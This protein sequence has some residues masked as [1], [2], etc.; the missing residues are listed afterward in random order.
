[1]IAFKHFSLPLCLISVNERNLRLHLNDKTRVC[2]LMKN[3]VYV[4][5]IRNHR[6]FRVPSFV[7]LFHNK[8]LSIK[9]FN[10]ATV[11]YTARNES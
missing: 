1:M 11:K 9:G 4:G 7:L 2:C 5:I 6:Q 3:I 10:L 8:S